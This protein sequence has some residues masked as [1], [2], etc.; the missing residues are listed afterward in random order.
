[1][2][3]AVRTAAAAAADWLLAAWSLGARARVDAVGH[4]CG[5]PGSVQRHA[6][7]GRSGV[8]GGVLRERCRTQLALHGLQRRQDHAARVRAAQRRRAARSA[9]RRPVLRRRRHRAMALHVRL[10]RQ[11]PAPDAQGAFLRHNG[12]QRHARA[13]GHRAAA[14]APGVVPACGGGISL[15]V[16]RRR[17]T[18][19][20]Q[21]QLRLH[22]RNTKRC[23]R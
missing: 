23:P 2:V 8:G 17:A 21:L 10:H 13:G 22:A 4:A 11:R 3:R 5:R 12:L 19:A 20:A 9:A 14:A 7:A 15:G 6:R 18:A 1:M 16:G